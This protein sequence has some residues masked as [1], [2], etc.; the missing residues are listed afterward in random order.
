MNILFAISFIRWGGVNTWMLEL[1]EALERRGHPV[2]IVAPRGHL[3]LKKA[4]AAGLDS[5]D[6]AFGPDFFTTPIWIRELRRRRIDVAMTN[7]SKENRTVGSAARMLGLP[8]AQ[9][10]GLANDL[11]R[12]TPTTRLERRWIVDRLIAECASM[13]AEILQRFPHIDSAKLIFIRPGKPRRP[14]VKPRAELQQ[15]LG[16]KPGH[17]NAVICSQLTPGKGHAELLEAVAV[18]RRQKPT[19]RRGFHLSIFH[20]GQEAPK[21]ERFIA[22]NQLADWVV[23][24]GF[25]ERVTDFLP[26]FDL[27]LLPSHWE[28]LANNLREYMMA[29]LCPVVSD[30]PG[31]T[32]V[33]FSMRNGLV[34]RT[35]DA[36]DIARQLR[37][38]LESPELVAQFQAQAARDA[39][40]FFGMEG[41]V[42]QI[43]SLFTALQKERRR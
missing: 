5:C 26:A 28:G 19:A 10:V 43:E 4:S 3:M 16:L 23:M 12:D 13:R 6:R 37:I 20:T 21:L 29:G 38:A 14:L 18:L 41:S 36:E 40:S 34:H 2:T 32:E 27:G 33:V 25:S 22:E 24:R 17:L 9:W 15:E 1:G 31:T 30:I 7:T 11:K 39:E 8:V 42:T 35:G